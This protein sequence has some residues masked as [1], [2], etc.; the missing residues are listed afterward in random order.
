LNF[1]SALDLLVEACPLVIDRP[2]G[3][4]H[5]RYPETVYP[6]DYGH[7]EGTHSS[8]GSGLDVWV[9]SLQPRRVTGVALTLDLNKRDAEMKVL[10]GC[11]PD[12]MQNVN[13]FLDQ[14]EM[15]AMLLPRR[16][17]GLEWLRQRRSVRRFTSQPLPEGVLER[18]LEAAAWAPSSHNSQPWRFVVLSSAQSRQELAAGLGAEFL[19]DLLASGVKLEEARA[20]VERSSR[21][22]QEAPAAIVLCLD[23]TILEPHILENRQVGERLMAAQSVAMAGQNLLLAAHLS[24]LGGVW[25]CAPLFA[26][27][28]VRRV[29][30]LPETWQ[31]QGMILLGFPAGQPRSR[32]RL[33]LEKVTVYR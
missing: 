29:L 2:K 16:S 28:A 5:P 6:L 33:P 9:G 15:R 32:E 25:L 18:L 13:T 14:G 27:Q 12:E 24:G 23:E 31:P 11:T 3:S 1:W 7:L 19:K 4:H 21:R 20:Q 8:D 17:D 30:D 26:P 10:L 22:I